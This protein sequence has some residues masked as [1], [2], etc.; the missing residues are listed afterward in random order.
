MSFDNPQAA[1]FFW[2]LPMLAV[3][4]LLSQRR[5]W[6][7]LSGFFP[8]AVIATR[9][10]TFSRRGRTWQF[11]LFILALASLGIALLK[12]YS[13]FA[14]REIARRGV[15]LFFLVDTSRS[16]DAADVDKSRLTRARHEIHDFLD[17]LNG[18]R[19]GLIAFAGSPFLL[20]PLTSDYDTFSLF[21]DEIDTDLIPLQGTDIAGGLRL[22]ISAFARQSQNAG[23]A[24][25]LISDGESTVDLAPDLAEDIKQT[26]VKVF[27]MGIGTDD[28]APIPE[29]SGG[30][31]TNDVGE[32]IL[33]HLNEPALVDLAVKTGGTYVRS[34]SGDEDLRQ[35]YHNGIKS[36]LSD[37]ELATTIKRLP[38]YDFQWALLTGFILLA[39]ETLTTLRRR[40]WLG[41][42][43]HR[44]RRPGTTAVITLVLITLG[45]AS[46]YGKN[47]YTF[48]EA[49]K[50]YEA[51]DYDQALQ[52]FLVLEQ[53]DPTDAEVQYNLGNTHFRRQ[54]WQEAEEA[55]KKA[56]SSKDGEI[57]KHA[58]YN[59]GN[60]M[61][62]QKRYQ[63]AIDYYE[64]ALQIDPEY[65]NAQVN[66]ELVKK[67]LE[68]ESQN[69]KNSDTRTDTA[70]ATDSQTD[71][72]TAPSTATDSQTQTDTATGTDTNTATDVST[73]V[74]TNTGTGTDTH[75]GT[76]T[77]TDTDSG[78]AT[79]PQTSTGTAQD[80]ATGQLPFQGQFDQRP[81]SWL[82]SLSD[83][84][85]EALK[86]MIQKQMRHE[87]P[88]QNDKDW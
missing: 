25:I 50:D 82:E 1:A 10:P 49:V 51:Q 32:I 48:E 40:Y 62:A 75:T 76:N 7:L 85:G 16:M 64:K 4:F 39:L 2:L 78:Q 36:V 29:R 17:S 42:W 6:R 67:L 45:T 87:P 20:V 24:V 27:V 83:E 38:H 73:G 41:F 5:R 52:R 59:L 79:D 12:P 63:D 44:S 34:V 53:Q 35:I 14:E 21:L 43:W 55:Y 56:L 77:S 22:A 13:G 11:I 28:G 3:T 46:A 19:A 57:R 65:D 84:P 61:A 15:D 9:L 80:T 37:S 72:N 74:A 88:P 47:P 69:Q 31:K 23:R 60:T 70:T 33:S 66:L 18:D 8:P 58:L 81:D 68:Q 54:H 71:T 26:G 86:H 30:Y